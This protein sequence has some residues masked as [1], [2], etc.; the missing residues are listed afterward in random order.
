MDRRGFLLGGA[1]VALG[2]CAH[3]ERELLD[4]FRGAR[5]ELEPGPRR[6]T[7]TPP[8]EDPSTTDA[9]GDDAPVDITPEPDFLAAVPEADRVG[10]SF[11]ATAVGATVTTYTTSDLADPILEFQNP[12]ASGGPLTFLVDDFEGIDRYRVLLPTRPNGS[13]GWID[14]G[15]VELTR[16]NYAIRVALDGHL[17]TLFDHDATLFETT[18][19]VARDNAPTPLGRYYTTE[20]IRP[21]QP[22]SVYGAYAY[23]LSGYSDTFEEFAGGA[24]QLGIHGTNDPSSIGENVSSG[25]IRM[26]NDDISLLVEDIGLPVGVPVEVI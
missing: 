7:T 1:A 26:H 12:I 10:L 16:H 2:A 5:I 23:G 15:A 24:G 19:G 8:P 22:H 21:V 9:A 20:L 18:V 3:P 11:V 13:F 14:A 25:C 17:F 4:D 6:T